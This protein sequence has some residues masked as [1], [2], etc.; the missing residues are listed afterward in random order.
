MMLNLAKILGPLCPPIRIITTLDC[1]GR[2]Y[3]CHREGY[4][5]SQSESMPYHIIKRAAITARRAGIK[6]LSLSGGEPTMRPDLPQIAAIIRKIYP[7][8]VLSLTTNGHFLGQMAGVILPLLNNLDLSITSLKTNIIEKFTGTNPLSVLD[9][10]NKYRS[11]RLSININ[12]VIIPENI[13]ELKDIITV[14]KDYGSSITF[15]T[16]L[17]KT[18]ESPKIKHAV[19]TLI[20]S[21]NIDKLLLKSTPIL[22]N[23]LTDQTTIKLKLPELSRLIEWDK[24][25]ECVNQYDC[26]EYFC[27]IR[28]YPDGG[29]RTCRTGEIV[30]RIQDDETANNPM[31]IAISSMTSGVDSWDQMIS[32]NRLNYLFN[33]YSFNIE[34]LPS[35]RQIIAMNKSSNKSL[36]I[37]CVPAGAF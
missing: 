35:I 28:V 3:Y 2:C 37:E 9:D 30:Q 17:L 26:G 31:T 8:V 25:T 16:P 29:I 14:A 15:M 19:N 12:C 10:I 32:K 22:F 11:S 27:A 21:Y 18:V 34:S 4:T 36:H 13:H 1:N 33:K 6:R 7:D 24:C 20:N 5:T 23:K